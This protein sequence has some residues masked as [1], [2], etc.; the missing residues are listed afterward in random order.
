MVKLVLMPGL[1]VALSHG[2]ASVGLFRVPDPAFLFVTLLAWAM[3]TAPVAQ[4]IAHSTGY[5]VQEVALLLF[6]Q[7][8][9]CIVVLPPLLALFLFLGNRAAGEWSTVVPEG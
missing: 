8:V 7:Y 9:A 3:P 1:G 5:G 2:L 4:A 6:W